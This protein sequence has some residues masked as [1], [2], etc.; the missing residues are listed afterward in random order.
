M[1]IMAKKKKN[2]AAGYAVV[3]LV[4][5]L[6]ACIATVLLG[7]AKGMIALDMFPDQNTETLDLAFNISWPLI[8]IGLLSY[9]F[10]TPD[11]IRRF[12]AGRQIR[13]GSNAL[14][15]A[16]AFLGIIGAINVL[17]YQ[18]PNFLDSPWDLTEDKSN[19]LADETL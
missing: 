7:A 9:A 8:V 6:I 16:V 18:N 2:S 14:I 10:M 13:Y 5:A 1:A 12:L 11:T 17:A 4:I 3:G 19:T 15:L